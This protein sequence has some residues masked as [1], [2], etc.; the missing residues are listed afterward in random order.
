M[1]LRWLT[2]RDIVAIPKSTKKER[3]TENFNIF[4]FK[5]NKE[6]MDPMATIDTKTS[7]FFDHRNPDEVK[8]LSSRKL[9]I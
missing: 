1:I 8:R 9:D 3:L 7:L 2:R 5:L 6:G 4:D